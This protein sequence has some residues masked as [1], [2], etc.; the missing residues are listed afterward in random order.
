[1]G[2]EEL[3]ITRIEAGIRG[4]K[5]GTKKPEDVNV[6]KWI[7][8]LTP[9]NKYMAEDLLG[10]YIQVKKNYDSKKDYA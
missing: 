3:F 6:M 1:M 10:K 7:N 4:I 2:C 8:K 5:M 9:L